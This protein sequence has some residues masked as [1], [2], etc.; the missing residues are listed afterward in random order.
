MLIRVAR[1]DEY[2]EI[3]RVTMRAYAEFFDAAA[4][5]EDTSYLRRIGDVAGRADRTTILVAVDED[6]IDRVAHARARRPRRRQRPRTPP[7]RTR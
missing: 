6:A 2:D 3:G 1:P 5:D 4:I 7:A